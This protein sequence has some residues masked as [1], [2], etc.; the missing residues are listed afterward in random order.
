M[1]SPDRA[2]PGWAVA[3][4]ALAPVALIGGWTLAA[5]RQ[6]GHFSPVHQTISALAARGATDRW[7]MTAGLAALGACH[8]VTALG[9]R[10][11][12]RTGRW[13]LAV[14]GVATAVV[15]AAP[16]PEHGSAPLHLAAAGVGFVTLSLWPAFASRATGPAVLR[17]HTCVAAS[18]VL[19][20]L[21]GWLAVEIGDDDL[22]GLSER[23]LAGAQALW[24]LVVVLALRES[25]ARMDR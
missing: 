13:L 15:A 2:V 14:G 11:A 10:P 22:V 25:A 5:S 6:P 7:I 3:S 19:L 4:A 16:Q 9:L 1:T 24:P 17:R 20:G 23:M 8:V 21:L 12:R 18:A